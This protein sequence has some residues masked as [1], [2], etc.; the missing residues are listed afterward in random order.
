MGLYDCRCMITGVS[1]KGARAVLVL[2]QEHAGAHLPVALGVTGS[3][4]RLGSLDMIDEDANAAA[5]YRFFRGELLNGN[6]V[7]DAP[8]LEEHD[9]YPFET[10]EQLVG[11]FERNINDHP[12]AALL[13]G[14]AP[15]FA[16]ISE[17]IWRAIAAAAKPHRHSLEEFLQ[18]SP[19]AAQ[20]YNERAE[21]LSKPAAEML[22][23]Q[24]FMRFR[25]L[26]WERANDPEQHYNEDM[27]AYIEQAQQQF[28]DNE[29]IMAGLRAYEDEVRELLLE[30]E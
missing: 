10:L 21:G 3:Y 20:I 18:T 24:D 11:A 4:N 28:G 29:I 5:I 26:T 19:L 13:N 23:V 30:N 25:N 17:Q 22:G 1:L 27:L 2:L 9:F 12:K 16:L 7:V 15:V 8:Y 14:Q 6:L